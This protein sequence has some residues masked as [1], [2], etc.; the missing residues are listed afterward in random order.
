MR[1]G[2]LSETLGQ[3]LKREREARSISLE[4]L[5]HG[6][7]INRPFLEALERNDFNFFSQKE[8]VLGFLKRYARFISLDEQDVLRRFAIETELISRNEKFEQ[9]PLFME[10]LPAGERA[11]GEQTDS[12]ETPRRGGR[13]GRWKVWLKIIILGIAISLTLYLSHLIKK[14][15][16]LGERGEVQG[17]EKKEK[18]AENRREGGAFGEALI[19][20]NRLSA[21]GQGKMEVLDRKR[22]GSGKAGSR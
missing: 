21:S 13:K 4:E 10:G 7:R 16:K 20:S 5:S 19:A 3:Y 8:F 2:H 6:T 11:G 14:R 1:S 18:K 9:M 17:V 22:P 15:E 12:V